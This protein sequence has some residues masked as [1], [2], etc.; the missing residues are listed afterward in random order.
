MKVLIT[1]GCGFIGVNLVEK[2]LQSSEDYALRVID[3][4]SVGKKEDLA[5]VSSFIERGRGE[6]GDGHWDRLELVVGDVTE[7]SLA[8]NVCKGADA[9]VHL[10]A[11]TG[12]IPSVEDPEQDFASNVVGT[13]NYLEAARLNGIG[14]F[15]FASSG[16]PLGEQV[17]PVHEE[18]VPHP[19]SP[20]GAGKLCGEAYCSAYHGSFGL[21]T[22]VLRFGNVY[23]PHSKHKGSV[24]AKFI[25]HIMA[26]EPLPIYG[27][28]NQTRDFIYVEDLTEAILLA[29]NRADVGGEIFQIATHRE[30][31][32]AEA[33]EELNR[34]GE[35]YL[36]MRSGIVFE[37]ERRGE[38]RR[39]YSDISKARRMLGFEPRHDLK[40][41]LEKTFRWFLEERR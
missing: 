12:V 5:R 25:R 10:A 20:Y 18:M 7:K 1:G 30:H 36:S 14:R 34:L 41:G 38:I 15:V 37:N 6:A 28:G 40:Q 13:F 33:A 22:V 11:S 32:V 29:L 39:N 8:L 26:S 9:V 4:L 35:K 23:G 21:E 16:A 3:N 19:I 31:T 17:P 2:L 24:V 27:D